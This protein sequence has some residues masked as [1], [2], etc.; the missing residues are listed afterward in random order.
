MG[1]SP[2][3]GYQDIQLRTLGSRPVRPW[4]AQFGTRSVSRGSGTGNWG[5]HGRTAREEVGAHH[6]ARLERTRSDLV[7]DLLELDFGCAVVPAARAST[8]RAADGVVARAGAELPDLRLEGERRTAQLLPLG[9]WVDECHRRDEHRA[10]QRERDN[11]PVERLMRQDVGAVEAERGDDSDGD[12]EED[13]AD[14]DKL[15]DALADEADTRVH[16]DAFPRDAED[17]HRFVRV[18]AR[19]SVDSCDLIDSVAY[20][21]EV[22]Q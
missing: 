19:Q 18:R 12:G 21:V 17:V 3:N 15:R 9:Q 13:G 20:A 10:R 6:G 4:T 8:W 1:A 5:V 22:F 7:G 2:P 16:I 14:V 11:D